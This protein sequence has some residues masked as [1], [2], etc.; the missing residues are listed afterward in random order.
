ML[1]RLLNKTPNGIDRILDILSNQIKTE[2]LANMQQNAKI[3][4]HVIFFFFNFF[5]I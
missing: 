3:I 2:G 4:L 1:Y 5:F